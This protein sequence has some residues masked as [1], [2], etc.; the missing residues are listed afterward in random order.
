MSLLPALN[1]KF[2]QA[3]PALA[4]VPQQGD[5]VY[6]PFRCLS[7][8][9]VGS[10]TWKATDFS[11]GNVLKNGLPL[12]ENIPAYLNHDTWGVDNAIGVIQ[13]PRWE[14]SYVNEK[15]ETVPAGIVIDFVIDTKLHGDLVRKLLGAPDA[16]PPV[17]P[18]L[19]SCSV[20]IK[21]EWTPSHDF[22]SDD[23]ARW[24]FED[25]IG[26]MLDG[27]EVCRVVTNIKEFREVS[28]VSF[29]A[30]KHAK[31]RVGMQKFSAEPEDARTAYK[32]QQF[33]TIA[34]GFSAEDK[35]P[36]APAANNNTPSELEFKALQDTVQLL[37]AQLKTAQALSRASE[38]H[39]Q[40]LAEMNKAANQTAAEL[41]AKL[42]EAQKRGDEL[43]LAATIGETYML[44][45]QAD[46]HRLNALVNGDEAKATE[47]TI[48][49]ADY[50]TLKALHQQYQSLAEQKHPVTCQK[51]GGTHSRQ[52][53]TPPDGKEEGSAKS[54]FTI[55]QE[56]LKKRV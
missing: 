46:T 1:L 20:G 2:E 45:L 48:E 23:A 28:I 34:M 15:G 56:K 13:N 9:I 25:A 10:G 47:K 55:L 16:N 11:Q 44:E 35:K 6:I 43:K 7:L 14:E 3:T 18:T 31:T 49:E 4:H 52:S 8:A 5:Y 42:Q 53:S 51:C 33:Y 21:F 40:K 19:S 37:E 30:D 54:S 17:P 12:L 36:T 24:R 41:S 27:R 39:A 32:E 26:T 50:A 22:G 29:G 38:I